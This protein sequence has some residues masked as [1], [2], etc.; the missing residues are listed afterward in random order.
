VSLGTLFL[1]T[2]GLDAVLWVLVLLGL[3]TVELPGSSAGP[4]YPTFV[5]PYSHGLVASLAWSAVA[6][7]LVRLAGRGVGVALVVGATV[8]SHFIL[9]ALVHVAG[10]PMLGDASYHLGL[11]LWRHAGL[12]LAVECA[13]GALGW[14]LYCGAPNAAQGARRWGLAAA[15]AAAAMLT[16]WGALTTAPPPPPAAMAV[17]SL[18]TIGALTAL[19]YWLDP[20]PRAR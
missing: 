11:G 1:A 13:L 3:E 15:V 4:H 12:E 10:L 7:A 8:F 14:W 18:L 6:F 20:G 9:D 17:S 16:I 5:F 19:A 2:M